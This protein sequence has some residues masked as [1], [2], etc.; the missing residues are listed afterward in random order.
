MLLIVCKSVIDQES[1]N[2][3]RYQKLSCSSE[4]ALLFLK[5][6]MFLGGL[7]RKNKFV[8]SNR[9]QKASLIASCFLDEMSFLTRLTSFLNQFGKE[10]SSGSTI[11]GKLLFLGRTDLYGMYTL[12]ADWFVTVV[13][14]LA[15]SRRKLVSKLTSLRC[16]VT[17]LMCKLVEEQTS[18]VSEFLDELT[19]SECELFTRPILVRS[20]LLGSLAFSS[21]EFPV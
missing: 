3:E 5:S 21:G 8:W 6:K 11:S 12:Q 14:K 4:K 10:A 20:V 18:S 2:G 1:T 7:L 9:P 17:Y 16:Q 13:F 15:S 19:P